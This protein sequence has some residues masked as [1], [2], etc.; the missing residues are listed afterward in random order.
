MY[1]NWRNVPTSRQL[2]FEF[3][4]WAG[5]FRYRRRFP[6]QW[7]SLRRRVATNKH[8]EQTRPDQTAVASR[9]IHAAGRA[10]FVRHARVSV[11]VRA[12]HGC[13]SVKNGSLSTYFKTAARLSLLC[14]LRIQSW[15]IKGWKFCNGKKVICAMNQNVTLYTEFF[16]NKVN[17]FYRAMHFSAKRGIAIVYC[18]SVCLSVTFRY[19]DQIGWNSSK[20][21]SRPNS[22]RPLPWLTPW[23]I[24]CN[25]NPKN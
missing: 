23:A 13:I 2:K 11:C 6:W 8:L 25:G 17:S 4:S 7:K 9:S 5:P 14:L 21:I 20:I 15:I 22:L 3:S 18:P 10:N 1:K 12:T 19:H 24:W 16:L